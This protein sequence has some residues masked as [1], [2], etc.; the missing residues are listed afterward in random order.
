MRRVYSLI[1][2]FV[3]IRFCIFMALDIMQ[4]VFFSTNTYQSYLT[5]KDLNES[6]FE[7]I[8]HDPPC[9]NFETARSTFLPFPM[10]SISVFFNSKFK[11]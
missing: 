11:F 3:I 6:I 4:T 8:R 7:V 1:V 9:I 2:S 10:F 5:E